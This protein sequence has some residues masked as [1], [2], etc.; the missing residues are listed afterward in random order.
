MPESNHLTIVRQSMEENYAFNLCFPHSKNRHKR[1]MSYARY[2]HFFATK[3][4]QEYTDVCFQANGLIRLPFDFRQCMV[5]GYRHNAFYIDDVLL[6]ARTHQPWK[7]HEILQIPTKIQQFQC[8]IFM[9]MHHLQ[10][11]LKCAPV[12][13]GNPSHT[14]LH[15]TAFAAKAGGRLTRLGLLIAKQSTAQQTSN[16]R[17]GKQSYRLKLLESEALL[18]WSYTVTFL[19]ET[20]D[21]LYMQKLTKTVI[22]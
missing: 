15:G 22:M 8:Y 1:I 4:R 19:F 6:T 9:K 2:L 17:G 13:R 16:V 10:S 11:I 18:R 20:N 7:K 14:N 12:V 3:I 5:H 21:R